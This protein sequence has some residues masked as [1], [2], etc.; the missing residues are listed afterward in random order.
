MQFEY[1]PNVV[2]GLVFEYVEYGSI[3]QRRYPEFRGVSPIKISCEE[4]EEYA[5]QAAA[6]GHDSTLEYLVKMWWV[7][8]GQLMRIWTVFGTR[9]IEMVEYLAPSADI[10][11]SLAAR[12]AAERGDHQKVDHI[13]ESR[14]ARGDELSVSSIARIAASISAARGDVEHARACRAMMLS[15]DDK[16]NSTLVV[17]QL[18]TY[19]NTAEDPRISA[20]VQGHR[21][22]VDPSKLAEGDQLLRQ[23]MEEDINNLRDRQDQYCRARKLE[24]A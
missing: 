9:D 15:A 5:N 11:Y 7:D 8:A 1:L 18:I 6:N 16:T 22:S 12:K 19:Q 17:C 23:W 21:R 10:S 3:I 13:I 24:V 4:V 14:R 20:M 2:R